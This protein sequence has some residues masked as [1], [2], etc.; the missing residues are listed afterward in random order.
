[1]VVVVVVSAA[2]DLIACPCSS[3][4]LYSDRCYVA[5]DAMKT[6]TRERE[7]EREKSSVFAAVKIVVS[8]K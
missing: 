5:F 2:D 7:R 6:L 3:L 1:M 4:L 8:S